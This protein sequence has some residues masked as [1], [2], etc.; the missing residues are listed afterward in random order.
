MFP[1]LTQKQS[2]SAAVAELLEEWDYVLARW[3]SKK[4]QKK[5]AGGNAKMRIS[6]T[7]KHGWSSA[8]GHV[9][10]IGWTD[11]TG[12]RCVSFQAY[13]QSCKSCG[14]GTFHRMYA[15][16]KEALRMLDVLLD[17]LENPM[18]RKKRSAGHVADKV[19]AHTAACNKSYPNKQGRVIAAP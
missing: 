3:P 16:D 4:T 12:Q 8:Q 2:H 15:D 9:V 11:A 14:D 10:A 18:P 19:S 13:G 1:F 5:R 6:C 17:R 7:A